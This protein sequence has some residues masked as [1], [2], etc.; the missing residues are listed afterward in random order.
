MKTVQDTVFLYIQD[1]FGHTNFDLESTL[2]D[3][4][5]FDSLDIIELTMYIEDELNIEVNDDDSFRSLVTVQDLITYI[6]T[7]YSVA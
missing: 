5:N 6:Q 1:K 4:L 2:Y 3:D 7:E